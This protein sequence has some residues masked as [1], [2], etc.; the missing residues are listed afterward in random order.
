M[1]R[2]STD[3]LKKAVVSYNANNFVTLTSGFPNVLTVDDVME[4][5]SPIFQHALELFDVSLAFCKFLFVKY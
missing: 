1:L 3:A 2:K 5:E 4:P